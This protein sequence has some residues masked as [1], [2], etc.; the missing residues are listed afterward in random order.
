MSIP[1][2]CVGV[3]THVFMD[4]L[5]VDKIN[6]FYTQAHAF[7][8]AQASPIEQADHQV[9]HTSESGEYGVDYIA[10]KNRGEATRAFGPLNIFKVWKWLL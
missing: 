3:K 6:I 7:H 8:E 5:V 4:D 2:S 1:V 9:G 10:G